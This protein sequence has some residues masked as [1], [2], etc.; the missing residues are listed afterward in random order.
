[1][2][3]N[4]TLF[5]AALLTWFSA[6]VAGQQ[7]SFE[8]VASG[9]K[10][11]DATT[12]LRAI[13]ILRDADYPEAVVPIATTLQDSDDRVQLA[14]IDAERSLFTARPVAQRRMVAGIIEVRSVAGVNPA[15]GQLALKA[16]AVPPELLSGLTVA[17]RDDSLRVRAEAI[18]LAALLAPV[19]CVPAGRQCDQMGNALIENVNSRE[20][21]VRRSAMVAL[22]LARYES[23]AQA[24]TDQLSFY[25]R[26]ADAAAAAE[27][28]AGI[29]HPTS[30]SIFRGLLTNS[31]A[32]LRR[33]GIEGLARA[34]QRDALAEIQ[35][36][37]AQERSA[38]V[39]LAMHFAVLKLGGTGGDLAQIVGSLRNSALRPVALTYLLDLA[40]PMTS[41]IAAHLSDQNADVRRLIA[42]VLGF[43][44]NASVIPAL[45]TAAKDQDLGV[46]TAAQQAIARLKIP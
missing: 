42:G 11:A 14:A 22:G 21:T 45:S 46:A 23:A 19:A 13:Q 34:E 16:R 9:L 44:R 35:A 28:L 18:E 20:P 4:R 37:G 12:R 2:R 1:M 7:Y 6:H 33:L 25:Q 31:N 40:R 30:A 29:G 15:E 39:L 41:Q 10:H 38:A 43:S 32:D 5:A 27:G 26:G 24:L 17:L 3:W 8:E 36:L